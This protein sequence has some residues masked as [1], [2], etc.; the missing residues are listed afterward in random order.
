MIIMEDTGSFDPRIFSVASSDYGMGA[1]RLAL[2]NSPLEL[3]SQ[4]HCRVP[5]LLLLL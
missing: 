5:W 4:T 1:E 3:R 2:F